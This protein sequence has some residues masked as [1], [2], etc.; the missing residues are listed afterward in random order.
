MIRAYF[1]SVPFIAHQVTALQK[2]SIYTA[3]WKSKLPQN[4]TKIVVPK[5]Q[6]WQDSMEPWGLGESVAYMTS[7]GERNLPHQS[8]KDQDTSLPGLHILSNNA[9]VSQ[10]CPLHRCQK[11]SMAPNLLEQKPVSSPTSGGCLLWVPG[12]GTR[13]QQ[14]RSVWT[15]LP[16]TTAPRF[17]SGSACGIQG[18]TTN[19]PSGLMMRRGEIC[20]QNSG[21]SCLIKPRSSWLQQAT[22]RQ[23]LWMIEEGCGCG[24]GERAASLYVCML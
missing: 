17:S 8:R 6:K 24:A 7:P 11:L 19:S 3:T 13:I 20:H 1:V 21:T 14:S 2:G 9:P 15:T 5:R 22:Q 12:V 23:R 4:A 18:D 10:C 16:S